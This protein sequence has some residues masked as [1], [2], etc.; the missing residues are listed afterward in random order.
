MLLRAQGKDYLGSMQPR[1]KLQGFIRRHNATSSGQCEA[2]IR[3]QCC[4]GDVTGLIR[5]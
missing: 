2:A 3:R 4:A 5:A 1:R